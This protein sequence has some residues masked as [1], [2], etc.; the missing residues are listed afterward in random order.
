MA[1]YSLEP[2]VRNTNSDVYSSEC[3]ENLA[4][5]S[6]IVYCFSIMCCQSPSRQANDTS[7]IMLI[8]SLLLYF[9]LDD[10]CTYYILLYINGDR[11]FY[12]YVCTL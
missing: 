12:C 2:S 3:Y 4:L 11:S 7:V 6:P 5:S 10:Y 8:I 1:S 9:I